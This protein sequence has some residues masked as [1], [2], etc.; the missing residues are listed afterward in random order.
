MKRKI[1][2]IAS[3]TLCVS[4]CVCGYLFSYPPQTAQAFTGEFACSEEIKETYDLGTSFTIPN[5]SIQCGNEK[6]IFQ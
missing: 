1:G 4:A 3:I 6:S 2:I 5:G